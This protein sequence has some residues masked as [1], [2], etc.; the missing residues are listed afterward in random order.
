MTYPTKYESATTDSGGPQQGTL[1]LQRYILGRWP[2]ATQSSGI[3]YYRPV[4]GGS[5]LSMHAEGRAG[6]VH[7]VPSARPQTGDEIAKWLIKN[8]KALGIQYFIWNRRS[9]NPN[10][11]IGFRW[12]KY[13]GVNP[14]VDHVHYEQTMAAAVALTKEEILAT[15]RKLVA[16]VD[17]HGFY[18]SGRYPSWNVYSNGGIVALDGAPDPYDLE[19]AGIVP[20]QR[21]TSASYDPASGFLV[22]TSA[23][24]GGKFA[25]KM[26]V[27]D[28]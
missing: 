13:K 17:A 25:Y 19:E 5:A 12:R 24:D 8:Y 27:S 1:E 14:H 22:L 28:G 20:N 26:E 15:E 3:Y 18:K 4:R 10:R 23:A 7:V 11:L 2:A 6:D 16:N 21:I 9:W